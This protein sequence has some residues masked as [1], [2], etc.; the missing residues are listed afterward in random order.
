[1]NLGP[2]SAIRS[3]LASSGETVNMTVESPC[4]QIALPVPA[5]S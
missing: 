1:M 3:A 2:E 5:Y 4:R